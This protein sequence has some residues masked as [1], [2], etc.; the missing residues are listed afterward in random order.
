[1]NFVGILLRNACV[2]VL[3]FMYVQVLEFMGYVLECMCLCAGFHVCSS[4]GIH[5]LCAGMHVFIC[6]FS[7]VFKCWNSC[8]YMLEIMYALAE[9]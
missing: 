9:N 4:A 5:G 7:C 6:W 1:M 8:V 2:C 3:I